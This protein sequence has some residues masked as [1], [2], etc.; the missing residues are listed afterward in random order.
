MRTHSSRSPR[1]LALL[2]GISNYDQFSSATPWPLAAGAEDIRQL[3]QVLIR[4]HGFSEANV[5]TLTDA[6]ATGARIRQ[7]F[8]EHLTAQ[9][10][11]G[12]VVW[13]H[14]SGH[15]QQ[16]PDDNGDENDGLDESLVPADSPSQSLSSGLRHNI[17]DE[18]LGRWLEELQAGMQEEGALRGSIT[19]TLDTC[20][21]ATAT[22]DLLKGR[23]RRWDR[24]LDGPVPQTGSQMAPDD[25]TGIFPIGQAR[26]KGYVVMA[27]SG[28]PGNA[29]EK[30]GMG[31]FSRALVQA[32]A[33]V[34][35]AQPI[36]YRLLMDRVRSRIY[37]EAPA[38]SP[39]LEGAADNLL[40][41]QI[42][43]PSQRP[44][45][46]V[47]VRREKDGQ[48]TLHAGEV[49]GVTV[50]SRYELYRLDASGRDPSALI[51]A[52]VVREVQA[53]SAALSVEAI[54]PDAAR[55]LATEDAL[56]KETS[57]VFPFPLLRV[58]FESMQ[59]FPQLLR[60]LR[61]LN[62][63]TEVDSGSQSYDVEVAYNRPG[64]RF[65]LLRAGAARQYESVPLGSD[66]AARLGSMLKGAW[67]WRYVAQL[68]QDSLGAR[69]ALRLLPVT[70]VADSENILSWRPASGVA[71][72]NF[73]RVAQ[74]TM[75]L[76]EIT[77]ETSQPLHVTV[78]TVDPKGSIY[79]SI[80][81]PDSLVGNLFEAGKTQLYPHVFQVQGKPGQ[82]ILL[83]A[84]ATRQDI[85]FASVI[86][87]ASRPESREV[88]GM[89]HPLA[90]MLAQC[91][92]GKR[93]SQAS[94]VD[95]DAWSTA[96]AWI[97]IAR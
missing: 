90:S 7:L 62:L 47:L 94:S 37:R 58:H 25:E 95:P 78:L 89:L 51:G 14:F 10:R 12:D 1:R 92:A 66:A 91:A 38:Q 8:Q 73:L 79:P 34:R 64:R 30:D 57:H 26:K 24:N 39:H 54:R 52:A 41:S 83:K 55:L 82:R 69:V 76:V 56:A 96:E 13:F 50:G 75:F 80:P 11:P 81:Q 17:R 35:P 29:F 31:I 63:F 48:V 59:P 33:S 27:A 65:T 74:K 45:D 32:L 3:K 97:E 6:E 70:V 21:A 9:A 85:D 18:T 77:N 40:F 86:Y 68:Q 88:P 71:P 15:G 49:H 23:G 84:I 28:T 87:T 67:R 72:S 46:G 5:R 93:S 44:L 42:S 19:V 22:R 53:F 20:F 61:T 43:D 4:Q 36:T 2:I 16:L 60:A